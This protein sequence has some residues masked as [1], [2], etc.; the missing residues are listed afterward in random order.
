MERRFPGF[1]AERDPEDAAGDAAAEIEVAASGATERRRALLIG[2]R[3]YA[4]AALRNPVRDT[5]L[6]G[7]GLIQLGFE[8][9]RIEDGT[10]AAMR[11][12]IDEFVLRLEETDPDT[13]ALIYFSG[14]G[15]Q[16]DGVNYLIPIG[17]DIS[18]QRHFAVRALALDDVVARLSRSPRHANIIVMDACRNGALAGKTGGTVGFNKGLAELRLPPAGMLVAYSTSAGQGAD[19]GVGSNGPYATALVAALPG[20]LEPGRRIHD[21]FVETAERVRDATGGRYNPALF[22]QGGL[23]ALTPDPADVARRK[24]YDP[25]GPGR[26]R[27]AAL[28]TAGAMCFLLAL[29]AGV[30]LWFATYPEVRNAWLARVGLQQSVSEKLDCHGPF[31]QFATDR[32]GLTDPD[33]CMLAP[34]DIE[35]KARREP[36]LVQL[37]E[38]GVAEGD[39]KALFLRAKMPLGASTQVPGESRD[40]VVSDLGRA[41]NAGLPVATV[42]WDMLAV[43]GA[44]PEDERML[45]LAAS[46]G[47]VLA[48]ARIATELAKDGDAAAGKTELERLEPLDPTGFV[49]TQLARLL[50][51]A[52]SDT[53]NLDVGRA[54]ELTRTGAQ[55]GDP[56][57]IDA[58][59]DMQ[60]RGLVVINATDEARYRNRQIELGDRDGYWWAYHRLSTSDYPDAALAMLRTLTW[61]SDDPDAALALSQFALKQTG[62][63]APVA[64]D[65]LGR[66]LDRA[67]RAQRLDAIILR[68][69][70]RMGVL[71]DVHNRPLL[72]PDPQGA[73]RDLEAAI[74]LT[75]DDQAAVLLARFYLWGL[76]RPPDAAAAQPYLAMAAG[77]SDAKI[78]SVAEALQASLASV[79]SLSA[80][81]GPADAA[82]GDAGAAVT[83]IVYFDPLCPD[84][85]P[86]AAKNPME[87]FVLPCISCGAEGLGPVLAWLQQ[88]YLRHGFVRVVLRPV[89]SKGAST[90]LLQEMA[91]RDP[92]TR[93]VALMALIEGAPPPPATCAAQPGSSSITQGDILRRKSILHGLASGTAPI[94]PEQLP[95]ADNPELPQ[96]RSGSLPV[97]FVNGWHLGKITQ[98]A[99]GQTIY[100]LLSPARQSLVIDAADLSCGGPSAAAPL[101]GD[102]RIGGNLFCLTP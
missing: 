1:G 37:V 26:A 78:R 70:L 99:L 11:E 39:P 83:I 86:D 25:F 51:G 50:W 82:M 42:F 6:L 64:P 48:Q 77:S 30:W 35:I 55:K 59:F 89:A 10:L 24:S 28:A 88:T 63:T 2:N 41:A 65:E 15:V 87:N 96:A 13:V 14:H 5:R 16:S 34:V 9:T 95:D 90:D 45:A 36:D 97:V 72:P 85:T 73:K 43:A 92:A 98:S 38:S 46:R 94:A 68:A 27:R 3:R 66:A 4:G 12:A 21:V 52:V 80:D 32:Y 8:V 49:D 58:M 60:A 69:K 53:A 76:D 40:A 18:E 31:S 7:A 20:L 71:K 33:W 67:V 84:C 57:A 17:A 61:V 81:D 44:V 29:A 22:L 91:C 75:E 101:A 19:D 23:P 100:Q 62:L 79:A 47:H 102:A 74:S 56:L 54:I 93:V